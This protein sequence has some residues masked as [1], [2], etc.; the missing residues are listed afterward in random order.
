MD[1]TRRTIQRPIGRPPANTKPV[2]VAIAEAAGNVTSG[3]KYARNMD[4]DSLPERTPKSAEPPRTDFD[5][6]DLL[7]NP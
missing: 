6:H 4:A 3:E 5:P 2:S 7:K 1:R